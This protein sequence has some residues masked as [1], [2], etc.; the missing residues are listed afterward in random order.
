MFFSF[1]VFCKRTLKF[2]KV[3]YKKY[4]Y[5]NG[6]RF[7]PYYYET[8]R[9]NGKVVTKYLGSV[10]E[11]KKKDYTRL[12]I[13]FGVMGFMFFFFFLFSGGLTGNVLL[14][15]KDNYNLGDEVI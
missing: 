3:V 10:K 7:G 5:K 4:T 12:V 9:V 13:F 14:D 6:K 11:N 15:V 8:K 2:K 1:N